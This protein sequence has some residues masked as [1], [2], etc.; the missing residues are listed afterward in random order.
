MRDTHGL[1]DRRCCCVAF[2]IAIAVASAAG[3]A[4]TT[5]SPHRRAEEATIAAPPPDREPTAAAE[6]PAPLPKQARRC[7][8]PASGVAHVTSADETLEAYVEVDASKTLETPRGPALAA[9][10]CLRRGDGPARVLV[11]GRAA[12]TG[13]GEE[14]VLTGF[15][16]LQ[17][18]P[19]GRTLYFFTMANTPASAIHA[20]ELETGAERFVVRGSLL[21]FM[22]SGSHAG[23]LLVM[24]IH[25]DPSP[26]PGQLGRTA[27][28][29]F[30]WPDGRL[31]GS[32]AT[33][34][35][36]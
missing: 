32:G 20:V 3:C 18:G 25:D 9:S 11:E 19:D 31:V 17:L 10:I 14:D 26:P 4:A 34:G 15:D 27:K 13:M 28:W 16:S 30:V 22:G 33:P 36:P 7:K 8:E 24:Q 1:A 12:R 29:I 2:A 21:S 23:Q 6:A 35:T 5:P